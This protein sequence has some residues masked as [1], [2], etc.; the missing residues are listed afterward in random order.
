[1][2]TADTSP[3]YVYGAEAVLALGLGFS[4]Q[5]FG[6]RSSLSH[7]H[8]LIVVVTDTFRCDS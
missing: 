7:D 5:V 6:L 2:V 8:E 3:G 4:T 1:M